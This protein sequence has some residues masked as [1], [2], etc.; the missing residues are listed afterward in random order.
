LFAAAND[1]GIRPS[2]LIVGNSGNLRDGLADCPIRNAEIGL[3]RLDVI[4]NFVSG[5]SGGAV[6]E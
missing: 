2:Q 6:G 4:Y 1:A 5:N 3:R